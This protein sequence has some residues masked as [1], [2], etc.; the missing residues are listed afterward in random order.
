MANVSKKDY[1]PIS[2]RLYNAKLVI[3][4]E[5]AELGI[6]EKPLLKSDSPISSILMSEMKFK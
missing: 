1:F 2:V 6:S 5:I 3:F 4:C